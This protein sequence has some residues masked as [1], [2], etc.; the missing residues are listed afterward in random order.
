MTRDAVSV[1]Y[2]VLPA[3]PEALGVLGLAQLMPASALVKT[4]WE[5]FSALTVCK[6]KAV[7]ASLLGRL[8][9]TGS[10]EGHHVNLTSII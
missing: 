7:S 2:M 10:S 4:F 5:M 1:P 3:P 6:M 8:E 9:V